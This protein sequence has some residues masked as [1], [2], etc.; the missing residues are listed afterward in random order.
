MNDFGT[1]QVFLG[2]TETCAAH[3]LTYIIFHPW[4]EIIFMQ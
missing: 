3:A 2:E 1:L 4:H